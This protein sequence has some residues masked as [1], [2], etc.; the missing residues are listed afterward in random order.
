MSACRAVGYGVLVGVDWAVDTHSGY[1]LVVAIVAEAPLV[2]SPII[3]GHVGVGARDAR[4]ISINKLEGPR[5]TKLAIAA[6]CPLVPWTALT[7]REVRGCS[8]F[9][10]RITGTDLTVD[11]VSFDVLVSLSGTCNALIISTPGISQI[12][13]TIVDRSRTQ[14]RRRA[15]GRARGALCIAHSV[16]VKPHGTWHTSCLSRREV[17][18]NVTH[19]VID[20]GRALE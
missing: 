15:V 6:V 5:R 1:I 8:K 16:F 20:G 19:T 10:C 11:V 2:P 18:S 13:D 9:S 12:T 7:R 3:H 17:E 4:I 14:H